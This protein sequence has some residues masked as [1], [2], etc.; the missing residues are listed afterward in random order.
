MS[1]FKS[2]GGNIMSANPKY[3]LSS[4]L[5]AAECTLHIVSNGNANIFVIYLYMISYKCI[6]AI[7]LSFDMETNIYN[8][9][10][11]FPLVLNTD[12]AREICLSEEFFT[13][14]GKTALRP[15]EILLAIDIPHS[16]PV[17]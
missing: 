10:K 16:R 15:D 12:G 6:F 2:I 1:T 7:F 14:F 9:N 5:A 4:I 13:D 17:R 3:D 11:M 8:K